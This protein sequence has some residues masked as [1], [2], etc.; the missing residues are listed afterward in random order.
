[1]LEK[2]SGPDLSNVSKFKAVQEVTLR[3]MSL[4]DNPPALVTVISFWSCHSDILCEKGPT[5]IF[6]SSY[7]LHLLLCPLHFP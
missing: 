1:M 5:D 3:Q 4:I 7:L 2:L 6:I